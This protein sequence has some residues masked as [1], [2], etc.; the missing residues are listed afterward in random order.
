MSS[1]DILILGSEGFIGT[2]LCKYFSNKGYELWGADI[3]GKGHPALHRFIPVTLVNADWLSLFSEK[4]YDLCINASGKGDVHFSVIHPYED[5]LTNTFE[6]A[7]ILETIRVSGNSCRFLHISSAAIYGNP[8]QLPVKETDQPAPLSPYGFHKLMSEEICKEYHAIYKI[9][10]A[11]VRPF[12]VYGPGLKKQLLWDAYQKYRNNKNE[13]ELWGTGNESRDFIF[14]D[15]L[16]RSFDLI[17]ES[18]KMEGEVYNIASGNETT[19]K[20]VVTKLFALL[21]NKTVIKFNNQ[22]REGDPLNWKADISRIRELGFEP[23]TSLDKGL[24]M[25]VNWLRTQD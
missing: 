8:R 13:L 12:S 4:S 14:I 20:D 18:G 6:L 2:N 3:S 21:D 16:A 7:R 17:L 19:I 22:S 24:Q 11:I 15:D 1:K 10:I 9:P 25:L 5:Y 23:E